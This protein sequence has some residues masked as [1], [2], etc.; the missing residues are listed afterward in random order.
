MI[1]L[2]MSICSFVTS[3]KFRK[4]VEIQNMDPDWASFLYNK[5]KTYPLIILITHVCEFEEKAS[6][7]GFS[8]GKLLS[9]SRN[10]RVLRK[11][12]FGTTDWVRRSF[13]F[14]MLHSVPCIFYSHPLCT[15][16]KKFFFL[17]GLY[18]SRTPAHQQRK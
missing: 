12:Y 15:K 16:F 8:S 17:I 11:D 1:F 10:A 3:Y 18:L 6:F 4:K 9:N 2:Y 13:S 14:C 5:R 7:L